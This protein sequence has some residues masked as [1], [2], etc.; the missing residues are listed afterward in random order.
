M[1]NDINYSGYPSYKP[2][3]HYDPYSA[4]VDEAGAK[5]NDYLPILFVYCR[6]LTCSFREEK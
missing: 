2:Y 3:A 5:G 1:A 4:A 6:I